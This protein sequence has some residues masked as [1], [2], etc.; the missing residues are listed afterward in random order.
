M[1][2][3]TVRVAGVQGGMARLVVVTRTTCRTQAANC[4]L[5]RT[6]SSRVGLRMAPVQHACCGGA[7]A[8]VEMQL[9]A[10]CAAVRAQATC[11]TVMTNP[12]AG[13]HRVQA[14]RGGRTKGAHHCHRGHPRA[15]ALLPLAR[16]LPLALRSALLHLLVLLL[17]VRGGGAAVGGGQGQALGLH[18]GGDVGG[19]RGDEHILRH[20]RRLRHA[21]KAQR[22][23]RQQVVVAAS[24]PRGPCA[25]ACIT[26]T[27][28]AAQPLQGA[29]QVVSQAD[30]IP[31]L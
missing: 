17:V 14:Y 18:A 2:G 7:R 4:C 15:V 23:G 10:A 3:T 31:G 9:V 21:G 30:V 12:C 16:A 26:R 24:R 27:P 22:V 20:L 28:Q 11:H 29:G 19:A 8:E 6:G 25:P 1:T 13:A 5:A